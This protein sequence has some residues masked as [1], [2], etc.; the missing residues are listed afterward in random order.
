MTK[1]GP[2]FKIVGNKVVKV[3]TPKD[4]CT[5]LKQRHSK[6]VRVVKKGAG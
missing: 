2:G 5:K 4:L 3:D 6:R 1:I